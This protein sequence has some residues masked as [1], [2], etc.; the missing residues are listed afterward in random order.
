MPL[1]AKHTSSIIPYMGTHKGVGTKTN[2][3]SKQKSD[4]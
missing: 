2:E 4:R 3:N 1:T